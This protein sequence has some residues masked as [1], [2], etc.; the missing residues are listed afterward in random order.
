MNVW[1]QSVHRL[2]EALQNPHIELRVNCYSHVERYTNC[3]I[4]HNFSKPQ[5]DFVDTLYF[6]NSVLPFYAILFPLLLQCALSCVIERVII[7]ANNEVWA[8]VIKITV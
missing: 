4:I 6:I 5:V 2:Y 8:D 7:E 3:Y 1:K